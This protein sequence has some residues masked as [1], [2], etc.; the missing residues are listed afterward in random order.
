MV[1]PVPNGEANV[2]GIGG[3]F[4]A[5]FEETKKI[6]DEDT[7]AQAGV[8]VYEIHPCRG[9][10]GLGRRAGGDTRCSVACVFCHG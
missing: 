6:I 3:I 1:C 8:F 5:I 10:A 4:D 2:R 9:F 7:G